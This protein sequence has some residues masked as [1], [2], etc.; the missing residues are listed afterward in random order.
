MMDRNE[1]LGREFTGFMS[2]RCREL[3]M[4]PVDALVALT[5]C[6]SALICTISDDINVRRDLANGLAFAVDLY[7]SDQPSGTLQ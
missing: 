3:N 1:I 7:N 5:I 2:K 6:S 4:E